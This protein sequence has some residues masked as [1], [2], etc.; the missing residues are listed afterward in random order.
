M[1]AVLVLLAL[2]VASSTSS[3]ADD[4]CTAPDAMEKLCN[5][6]GSMGLEGKPGMRP[7]LNGVLSLAPA[8]F[9]LDT[10]CSDAC[11]LPCTEMLDYAGTKPASFKVVC[12]TGLSGASMRNLLRF[13]A[14]KYVP[15]AAFPRAESKPQTH[16]APPTTFPPLL[17]PSETA[18]R[19]S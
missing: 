13:R 5:V 4:V 17:P 1:K 18:C 6:L 3:R 16:D 12:G 10:L 15:L 8:A 19:L 11:N 2:C 9:G 14:P 7:N